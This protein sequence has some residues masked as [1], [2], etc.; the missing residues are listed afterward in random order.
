MATW[1]LTDGYDATLGSQPR[2]TVLEGN[3]MREIG[4]FQKQSSGWAQAKAVLNVVRGNVMFNMPRAAINFNDMMGG[5]DEIEHNLIFN[6]C[7]ESGDHGPINSWDRQPFL[8]TLSTPN[9]HPKTKSF[10]PLPRNIS[11]NFIFANYGASQGVD[12]DD[13]SSWFHITGNV[14]YSADGFKMDY[15][16]HDSVFEENIILGYPYDGQNCVNVGTF[17]PGHGHIARGNKCVSGL[18]GKNI[19]SGCG[20]PSC[21]GGTVEPKDLELVVTLQGG[22][23]DTAMHLSNNTYFTPNG[24]AGFVCGQER[25]QLEELRR[26]FPG[27]EA[28]SRVGQLPAV[29]TMVG[30]V[31]DLLKLK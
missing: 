11:G 17:A 10:D 12:N 28:G 29:S 9:G 8:T 14:F 19:P 4:V 31:V 6:S 24:T 16:G 1:G 21:A 22:C 5:G 23:Q 30:W 13:G 3:L 7:R 2:N 27:L 18:L 15:G 26:S 25:Y 20:D